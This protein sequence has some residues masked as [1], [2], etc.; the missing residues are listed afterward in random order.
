MYSTVKA[1]RTRDKQCCTVEQVKRI[2]VETVRQRENKR[3]GVEIMEKL[4]IWRSKSEETEGKEEL[5][6]VKGARGRTKVKGEKR[7][8]RE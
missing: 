1:F 7:V 8:K 4:P 2:G 6:N 5:K 3:R